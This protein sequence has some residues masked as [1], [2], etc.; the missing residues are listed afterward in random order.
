M[1]VLAMAWQLFVPKEGDLEQRLDAVK[2][3]KWGFIKINKTF[4]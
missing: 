1:F 2:R 3:M 4:I